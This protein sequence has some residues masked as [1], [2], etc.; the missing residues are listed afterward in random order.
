[1][2]IR[3]DRREENQ[4][5]PRLGLGIA[6]LVLSAA[7]SG[8]GQD[9]AAV[10]DAGSG[11][12][13]APGSTTGSAGASGGASPSTAPA[14]A[15]SAPTGKTQLLITL[16][17][18]TGTTTRRT[19]TCDPPGGDH[20][21]PARACATLATGWQELLA[22]T[23]KGLICTE[24]YGGPQQATVTGT[25]SGKQVRSSYTRTNGCEISRWDAMKTVL[26]KVTGA[27]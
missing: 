12:G 15:S 7:L 21:D 27:R 9:Q 22:P 20:A 25:Y 14:P 10:T 17:D 4:M 6:G 11:A 23:R 3:R 26:P 8:C 13:S 19:L 2:M 1:M 24:I 16:D 5:T 18:G